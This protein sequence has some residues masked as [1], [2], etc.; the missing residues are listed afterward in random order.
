MTTSSFIIRTDTQGREYLTAAD[1]IEP[2]YTNEKRQMLLKQRVY[3]EPVE[4]LRFYLTKLHPGLRRLFNYPLRRYIQSD[5]WYSKEPVGKNTLG[6][7]MR[8]ISMEAQLSMSYTASSVKGPNIA[9]LFNAQVLHVDTEDEI[10]DIEP[11]TDTLD[12]QVN[13]TSTPKLLQ[14]HLNNYYHFNLANVMG[15]I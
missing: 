7:F 4:I 6:Q 3:G 2:E 13:Y 9:A 11:D 10:T 14:I 12:Q 15:N 5:V 1:I 8:T